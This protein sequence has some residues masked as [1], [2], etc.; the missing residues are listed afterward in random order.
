MAC[1]A[2]D[3]S[4]NLRQDVFIDTTTPSEQSVPVIFSADPNDEVVVRQVYC[5]HCEMDCRLESR[6]TAS[7][8]KY[9]VSDGL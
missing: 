8:R 7:D 5:R 9:T 6:V 2:R 3:R 1:G 4:S